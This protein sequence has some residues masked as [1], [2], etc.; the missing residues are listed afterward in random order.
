MNSY[1]GS[2]KI[3]LKTFGDNNHCGNIGDVPFHIADIFG[4]V[5]PVGFRKDAVKD[6]HHDEHTN[7]IQDL[8]VKRK[9]E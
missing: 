3:C 4:A 7:N 6:A 1:R 8:N 9:Y 2:I 5:G